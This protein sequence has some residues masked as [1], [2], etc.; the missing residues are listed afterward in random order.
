MVENPFREKGIIQKLSLPSS[1]LPMN[2]ILSWILNR[3][4]HGLHMSLMLKD[5]NFKFH[6]INYY[7]LEL[8]RKNCV[9]WR[10]IDGVLTDYKWGKANRGYMTTSSQWVSACH[11]MNNAKC[12]EYSAVKDWK[13]ESNKRINS[14]VK[15]KWDEKENSLVIKSLHLVGGARGGLCFC[16][17]KF[18]R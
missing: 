9:Y 14:I 12:S 16:W 17:S 13:E 5:E 15:D 1:S 6:W 11:A 18:Y 3:F 7:E 10:C 8:I 2:S 4:E